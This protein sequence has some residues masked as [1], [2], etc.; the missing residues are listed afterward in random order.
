MSST[1]RNAK[2]YCYSWNRKGAFRVG[3]IFE[4]KDQKAYNKCQ[5]LLE[6]SYLGEINDFTAK[7]F[8]SRGVIVHEFYFEDSI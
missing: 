8:R 3:K 4:F 2:T 5:A 6:K 1:I 7:V